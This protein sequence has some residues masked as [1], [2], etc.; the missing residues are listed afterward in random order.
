MDTSLSLTCG[1][2]QMRCFEKSNE[3][4]FIED[5]LWL[6]C[7]IIKGILELDV[8]FVGKLFSI[9]RLFFPAQNFWA[10]VVRHRQSACRRCVCVC[11]FA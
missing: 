3:L 1:R 5:G 10:E 2:T 4:N 11:V 8:S 6:T 7:Y 9:S